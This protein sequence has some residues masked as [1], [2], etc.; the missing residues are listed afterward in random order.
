MLKRRDF[1]AAASLAGVGAAFMSH[2]LARIA[3]AQAQTKQLVFIFLRGG[4]DALGWYSPLGAGEQ[5]LRA[6]RPT[7]SLAQPIPFSPTL[8]ANRF[9]APMLNDATVMNGL[10]VVLHAGCVNET[11]SHFEQMGHVES[12][13][14]VGTTP[15]GFLGATAN[16][17]SK[18][19]AAIAAVMPAS[20]RGANPAC[21][22]DPVQL[23]HGYAEGS[24]GWGFSRQDRMGLYRF[25]DAQVDRVASL[26]ETQLNALSATLG[27]ATKESLT[28]AGGYVVSHHEFGQRL[29]VAAAVLAWNPAVVAVDAGH[30]WD[31][32]FAEHPNDPAQW[33]GVAKKVDDFAKNIV[34][35]KNDLVRR[36]RWNS[37]AIVV[38]SEFGRTVKEN[39]DHGTDHGR[40]GLM[41]LLGGAIRRHSDSSYLGLRS[42]TIPASADSSTALAVTHDYRVVMAEIIE[43]HLGLTRSSA[44]AL[45]RPEG[46]VSAANYLNV[47]R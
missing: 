38:L 32:H 15:S 44:L 37:T 1:I 7:L 30:D 3:H 16:A 25:G 17:L 45:F 29:A 42:F 33:Y 40:G 6:H 9:L 31:T 23:R 4:A 8:A 43:K 34:A 35:F 2:P 12:G 26:A 22:T 20:L 18:N 28:T 39:G 36:N 47:L 11:R 27:S 24:F 46:T 41:L 21:L 19:S 14:S 10:N 13:D 5:A